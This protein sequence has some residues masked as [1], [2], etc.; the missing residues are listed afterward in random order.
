MYGKITNIKSGQGASHLRDSQNWLK[1]KFGFLHTHIVF[2]DSSKGGF[3]PG[4]EATV[5]IPLDAD[6][7][8]QESDQ[9]PV[10]EPST[11]KSISVRS[12]EEQLRL[13]GFS[14]NPSQN[15][16][17]TQAYAIPTMSESEFQMKAQ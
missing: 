6:P 10:E 2:H 12:T 15:S 4:H 9:S 7:S 17:I 3:K 5:S 14:P 1:K 13:P 11:T 16:S 8:A